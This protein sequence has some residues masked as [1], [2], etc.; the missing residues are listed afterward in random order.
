MEI[1]MHGQYPRGVPKFIG[2]H[3]KIVIKGKIT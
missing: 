3:K 2:M 1:K